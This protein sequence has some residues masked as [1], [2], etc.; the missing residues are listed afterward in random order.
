MWWSTRAVLAVAAWL[1]VAAPASATVFVVNSSA[2]ETGSNVGNGRCE[3]E[4]GNGVCTLRRALEEAWPLLVQGGSVTVALDP[5][6]GRIVVTGRLRGVPGGDLQIVGGGAERTVIDG[7]AS[8]GLP[9]LTTEPSPTGPRSVRLSGVT[10]RGAWN[11]LWHSGASAVLQDV[12]VESSRSAGVVVG[13]TGT[14]TVTD[15]EFTGN[16]GGALRVASP[17]AHSPAAVR[18]RRT[19]FRG[20]QAAFGAAVRMDAGTLDL[21]GVT[22]A[23]NLA[24]GSGGAVLL[25]S[26]SLRAVNT[27]FSGNRANESG[28][29]I[30]VRDLG[31]LTV[32]DP[33]FGSV[34]VVHSTFVSNRADADANGFG[35]GA[36]IAHAA[37]SGPVPRRVA[38]DHTVM[39]G[40]T[41]TAFTGPGWSV[42]PGSCD[43]LLT[44]DGPTL[45][46]VVDCTVSGTVPGVGAADLGPLQDNGG[47]TPTHAPL[48]GSTAIDGGLAPPCHDGT[49]GPL[50]RDQRGRMRPAGTTCDLGA[51]EA[52]GAVVPRATRHDLNGDGKGDLLWRHGRF[53]LNAAW[54]MDGAAIDSYGL[55][56]AV[57]D[58]LWEPIASDDFD[59]DG[60]ADIL[61]RRSSD[62]LTAIW[63]MDG[64][65]LRASAALFPVADSPFSRWRLA[66]TGDLDGDG[67]ADLLWQQESRNLGFPTPGVT[68]AWLLDGVALKAFTRLPVP[69]GWLVAGV[70]DADGDGSSDLLLRQ[71]DSGNMALWFVVH[72]TVASTATLPVVNE[73]GWVV[74]GFADL[75]GDGKADVVWRNPTTATLPPYTGG[76][77]AAWLL[78]GATLAGA[79]LLPTVSEASWTL[80]QIEDTDGDGRADLV[81]RGAGGGVARWRMNG[82]TLSAVELLPSVP[83]LDWRIR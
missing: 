57:G 38:L 34:T 12:R 19:L 30:F 6:G 18:V 49:G 45:F 52:G 15:S 7:F 51:V 64:L 36:A 28:G 47:P 4:P 66:G 68:V 40:N 1:S 55:L 63:L 41:K 10:I 60:K 67:R 54:L 31:S 78:N 25:E 9:L 3:T 13:G 26:A 71:P 37:P 16:A 42:V 50:L 44:A 5:P 33:T 76:G 27:T 74:A 77:T 81:W 82:L 23:D 73:P 22:F 46:D 39:A 62:G 75:N 56:Q 35:A 72:A 83:N 69:S 32:P 20:N 2:D 43:G 29:A 21:D 48:P 80:A 65:V 8:G 79:A 14:L 53:A 24:T 58:P 11:A 61:W 59:G 70:G 17:L